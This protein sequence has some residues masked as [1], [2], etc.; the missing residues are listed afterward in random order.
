MPSSWHDCWGSLS[1]QGKSSKNLRRRRVFG[2]WI[3]AH[4]FMSIC[5]SVF[6]LFFIG[7]ECACSSGPLFFCCPGF[8]ELVKDFVPSPD[9]PCGTRTVY[10][11]FLIAPRS[12]QV[13]S[14]APPSTQGNVLY[15]LDDVVY[16]IVRLR[17]RERTF[18]GEPS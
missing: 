5:S 13:P 3:N 4:Y 2:E 14:Q 1:L 16:N 17:C 10:V 8:P 9:W 18:L 6:A 11:N 7:L 15:D 12:G